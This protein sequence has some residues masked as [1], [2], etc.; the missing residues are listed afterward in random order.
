MGPLGVAGDLGFLPGR[1]FGI[2][3]L[4]RLPSLGFQA[5]NLLPDGGGSLPALQGTKFLYL[6]LDLGHRLF[7]VEIAAHGRDA[8]LWH[9]VPKD[10]Q[11]V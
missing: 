8:S 3:V 4:E 6:G 7:K 2:E 5:G 11:R 10:R 1:Q 9:G